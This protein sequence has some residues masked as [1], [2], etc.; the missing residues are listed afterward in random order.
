MKDNKAIGG[1]RILY[2]GSARS[3]FLH[4][5]FYAQPDPC[6]KPHLTQTGTMGDCR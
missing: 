4:S 3:Y 2:D 5:A 1:S 6:K